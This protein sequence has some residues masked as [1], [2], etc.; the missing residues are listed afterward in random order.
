M[1]LNEIEIVILVGGKG[2]RLSSVVNDRPK[3]LALINSIPFLKILLNNFKNQ[4]FSNF[5]LLT[6][7]MA[8]AFES[9]CQNEIDYP[10]KLLKENN[11]LGTG[12]AILSALPFISGKYFLVVNGDTFFDINFHDFIAKSMLFPLA[13]TVLCTTSVINENRYGF[14]SALE[15]G[16]VHLIKEKSATAQAGQI[17]A[18]VYFINKDKME[19]SLSHFPK[20]CSLEVDIFPKLILRNELY[21]LNLEGSFIDIGVPNDYEKAQSVLRNKF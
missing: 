17:N 13:A 15:N 18:G 1:N 21:A 7:H 6:G 3:A 11:P 14:I 8:E 10:V 20:S 4:K 12:G 16:V 2:T 19:Q 5:I 9:F